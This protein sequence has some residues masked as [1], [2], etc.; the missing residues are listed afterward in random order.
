VFFLAISPPVIHPDYWLFQRLFFNTYGLIFK[1][2]YK[3]LMDLG[4]RLMDMFVY[5]RIVNP[6]PFHP[7]F[8]GLFPDG[9]YL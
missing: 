4:C 5:G 2:P 7:L 3:R 6:E 8:Y 9:H 1:S